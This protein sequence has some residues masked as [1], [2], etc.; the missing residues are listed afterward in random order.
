MRPILFAL[1][2]SLPLTGFA[3]VY[4]CRLPNGQTEIST[5]PCSTGKTL[6]VRQEERISDAD[7]QAAERDL[8]R[9]R[10]FVDKREAARRADQAADLEQQRLNSR[11][12]NN[13]SEGRV[14]GSADECLRDAAQMGLEGSQRQQMEADCRRIGANSQ[15]MTVFVPYPVVSPIVRPPPPP[16][17]PRPAPAPTI[18]MEPRKR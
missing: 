3:Q 12:Q 16:P 17:Q 14:Y 4:K 9:V 7:R 1:L 13:N 2:L 6:D 5:Q 15:P 18:T 10:N 11:R 8:E